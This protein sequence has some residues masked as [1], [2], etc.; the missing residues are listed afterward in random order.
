MQDLL[1]R[2]EIPIKWYF[3]KKK[4]KKRFVRMRKVELKK[5]YFLY[6]YL[7]IDIVH[8]NIFL[9]LLNSNKK[10]IICKTAGACIKSNSK[11]KKKASEGFQ[12]LTL[13]IFQ[14]YKQENLK[15]IH[16]SFRTLIN[17]SSVL[18]IKYLKLLK[19]KIGEIWDDLASPHNGVRGR[20]PR[21]L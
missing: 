13:S 2:R 18:L 12:A 17:N 11:K 6:G 16:L 19:I 3:F 8:S 20:T 14:Y 1:F 4:P 15:G 9:T 21:R 7:I 10:F 5:V